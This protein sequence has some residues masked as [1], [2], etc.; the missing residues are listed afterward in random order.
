MAWNARDSRAV[1][2]DAS[3]DNNNY[4]SN[5]TGNAVRGVI[6][7][8]A[9]AGVPGRRVARHDERGV[10][11]S[12]RDRREREESRYHS[13]ED[14]GNREARRLHSYGN[15]VGVVGAGGGALGTAERP[16]A[17]G[18]DKN[19]ARFVNL[20]EAVCVADGE[21][22]D[23]VTEENASADGSHW[24]SQRRL[25][26][27]HAVEWTSGGA[28]GSGTGAGAG[29]R[30]LLRDVRNTDASQNQD[31]RGGGG[32]GAPPGGQRRVTLAHAAGS[33]VPAT[34]RAHAGEGSTEHREAGQHNN[35]EVRY[36]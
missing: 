8:D 1:E 26:F 29:E 10:V 32:G 4:N 35:Q 30:S 18:R 11:E 21:D 33:S 14:A 2:G 6:D 36:W 3:A 19:G 5:N 12:A 13:R 25:T 16:E 31:G 28:D 7:A 27:D 17:G 9:E 22:G 15:P 34:S 20:R 24:I 23:G